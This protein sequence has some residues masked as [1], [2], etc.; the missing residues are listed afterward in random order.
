MFGVLAAV[1]LTA[2]FG[3]HATFEGAT[4]ITASI[5]YAMFN[6]DA[7]SLPSEGFLISFEIID[8]VLLGA[9][10]AAVMLGKRDDEEESDESVTMADGGD[11]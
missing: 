10:A 5:G 4:G 9:L 11:R 7:G 8:V 2:D 6:L 1:F 3:S